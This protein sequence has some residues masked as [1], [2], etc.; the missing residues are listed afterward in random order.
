[1][2]FERFKQLCNERKMS[3]T[4]VGAVIGISKTTISY[5]RNTPGVIPKLEQLSSLSNYFDVSID[6][7]LGKTDIR[8]PSAVTVTDD[9][10]KFALF[11]ADHSQPIT[12]EM[13]ADVLAYAQ[14]IKERER[15]KNEP[16]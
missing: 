13:Y 9:D 6:Y 12:D 1:M 4:G 16:K 15:K 2:F 11:G 5:W 8:N 7:L 3:P 10:I 14:F